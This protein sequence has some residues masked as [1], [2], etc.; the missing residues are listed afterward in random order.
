MHSYETVMHNMPF[1]LIMEAQLSKIDGRG[2]TQQPV[3][4]ETDEDT[5]FLIDW[6]KVY[7]KKCTQS[8]IH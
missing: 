3:P 4:G 7:Q 2:W 8:I 6:V 1:Y 5:D